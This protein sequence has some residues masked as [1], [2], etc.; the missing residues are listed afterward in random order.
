MLPPRLI[1]AGLLDELALPVGYAISYSDCVFE[2]VNGNNKIRVVPVI[3]L[4]IQAIILVIASNKPNRYGVVD[5]L[6]SHIRTSMLTLQ[7]SPR[8]RSK[9]ARPW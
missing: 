8:M 3:V 2:S 5:V 4:P 7:I 9:S 6:V 1:K